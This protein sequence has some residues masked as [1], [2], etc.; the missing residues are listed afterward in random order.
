M[1]ILTVARFTFL[2]LLVVVLCVTIIQAEEHDDNRDHHEEPHSRLTVTALFNPSGI[3]LKTVRI[4]DHFGVRNVA[5][6]TLANGLAVVDGDIIYGTEQQLLSH[7][8]PDNFTSTTV[9]RRRRGLHRA[10]GRRSFSIFP[11]N[12]PEIW[13]NAHIIYKYS[14]VAVKAKLENIVN[15]AI[16]RWQL[17]NPFLVF[18][19]VAVSS[20]LVN[21]QLTIFSDDC[22]GCSASIGYQSGSSMHMQLQQPTFILNHCGPGTGLD[23]QGCFEN[24]ATHEFG[25]VL[26]LMHEAKRP[27]RDAHETFH[28]ENLKDYDA[29]K[30]QCCV[31]STCC[32][33][34]CQF[35]ID[36][37]QDWNGPYRLT[38]IMQY[39]ADA[40]AKPGTFTLAD[41]PPEMVPRSNLPFPDIKDYQ[42]V[43]DI[44]SK[45]CTGVCG[46]GIVEPGEQCDNGINN[47]VDG[48]S[49]DC[50]LVPLCLAC[51]PN[52]LHNHCDITT[53]CIETE[54]VGRPQC[55]CRAGYKANAPNT[56]VD[57]HWRLPF[58]GQEYR[59]FVAPG[60]ACNTLCDNP[61][62]APQDICTEVMV[63]PSC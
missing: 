18:D 1:K 16:R 53:S 19:E 32:G 61:W 17:K 54:V 31:P 50:K 33:Y 57:V 40:F 56:Q 9:A 24:E 29:T 23:N 14:T 37:T 38:S 25:H 26:G 41:R 10:P 51:D 47:Y 6:F 49:P 2:L 8:V 46:N 13:P 27:D 62:G 43:C 28:C 36:T 5:Y 11:A 39:R 59:V 52:P 35:T 15:D 42:R 7:Q 45:E 48:C 30:P 44:F 4:S 22:G 60:V 55:A 34:A 12:T 20:T 63:V 21:G 58:P 3:E